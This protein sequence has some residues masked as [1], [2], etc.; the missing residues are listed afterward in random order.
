MDRNSVLLDFKSKGFPHQKCSLVSLEERQGILI[1]HINNM[2]IKLH[3]VKGGLSAF[4]YTWSKTLNASWLL[5][6][7]VIINRVKGLKN[8]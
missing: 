1:V 8:N 7:A 6:D 4:Y 2:A 5:F 3:E